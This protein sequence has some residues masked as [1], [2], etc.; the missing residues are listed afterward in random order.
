MRPEV[1]LGTAVTGLAADAIGELEALAPQVLRGIVRMAV[2][3]DL[4]LV[5]RLEPEVAG[6]AFGL[7][8][9]EH[10]VGARVLVLALPDHELVLIDGGVLE[11]PRGPV[12]GA[13][14]AGHDTEMRIATVL[15]Q[16]RRLGLCRHAAR[17][18]D[19]DGD[20]G[21]NAAERGCLWHIDPPLTVPVG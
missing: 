6:D 19:E 3:A 20:N 10:L 9:Q 16:D 4:G 15:G 5:R 14:G 1:T 2:Q 11:R 17:E 12:T 18:P 21:S 13:A 7:L 8:V